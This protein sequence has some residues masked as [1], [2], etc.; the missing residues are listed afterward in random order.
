MA[1]PANDMVISSLISGAG[2]GVTKDGLGTLLLS[3][4]NLY[5]GTTTV[6][7][8]T[9]LVDGLQAVSP[10]S[11]NGG[12][13][14]GTGTVGAITATASGGT[15]NR[16]NSGLG[17]LSSGNV[18]LNSASTLVGPTQRYHRGQRLRPAQRHRHRES[19]RQHPVS[20]PRLHFP[21]LAT[22]LQSLTTTEPTPS[23]E[24][25]MA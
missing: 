1:R 13:L 20:F 3:G 24:L 22:P 10:I 6:T 15:I 14:G 25:S 4:N 12:T 2:V 18:I 17:I 21:L 7:A 16:G 9:L 5:S 8:G 11:L 23:R 19:W